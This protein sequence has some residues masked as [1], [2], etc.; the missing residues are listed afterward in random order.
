MHDCDFIPGHYREKQALR[1]ALRLRAFCIGL[2]IVIML[3]WVAVHHHRL[4]SAKAMSLEVARQQQQVTIHLAKKQQMEVERGK[5]Q[6]RQR[7]IGQLAEGADLVVVFA[8]ISRR[9]PQSIVLTELSSQCSTLGRFAA[10]VPEGSSP[11]AESPPVPGPPPARPVPGRRPGA[12]PPPAPPAPPPAEESD[13]DRVVMAGMAREMPEII[14]FA[15]ALENSPLF[16]R[17]QMEMKGPATWAGHSGQKFEIR[18]DLAR[19]ERGG[20]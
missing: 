4:A 6:D 19:L 17:V 2:L 5:L 1:R 7:L 11:E 10:K 20:R 9:M 13:V 12:E 14:E 16:D 18:C 3:V 8:D 15:A